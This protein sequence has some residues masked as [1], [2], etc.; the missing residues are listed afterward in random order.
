M[1]GKNVIGKWNDVMKNGVVEKAR[2]SERLPMPP[3]VC[4]FGPAVLFGMN[5]FAKVF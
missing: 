1:V 2:L 3:V 5:A 4:I